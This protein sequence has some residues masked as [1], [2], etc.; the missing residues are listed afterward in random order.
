MRANDVEFEGVSKNN[1]DA[2][3]R[4]IDCIGLL[5]TLRTF[6]V[7]EKDHDGVCGL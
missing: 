1:A 3:F 5:E 7:G 2:G 4:V 6:A